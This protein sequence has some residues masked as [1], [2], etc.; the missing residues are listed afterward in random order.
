MGATFLI[1]YGYTS[2]VSSFKSKQQLL[3][4]QSTIVSKSDYR[5][6]ILTTLAITLLNPHVYLD[7]V[8]IVGGIAG[9]LDFTHKTYFLIGALISSFVW[10]FSLGFGARF[11]TPLFQN[12]RN[13][14]ILEFIIGCIM[15]YIA[16]ALIKYSLVTISVI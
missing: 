12:P 11:L 16:Y 13:W 14:R 4:S 9:T 8:V 6:T 3:R 5:K 1:F 10:F 2:F 15:W 7:T